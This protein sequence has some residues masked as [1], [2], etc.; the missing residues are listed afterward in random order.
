MKLEQSLQMYQPASRQLTYFVVGDLESLSASALY[1]G[2]GPKLPLEKGFGGGLTIRPLGKSS[3]L[4]I[5]EGAG[6]T[7]QIKTSKNEYQNLNSYDA[8]ILDL[9]MDYAGIK[10]VKTTDNCERKGRK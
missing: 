3:S 7:A 5:H 1:Y 4:H 10:K 2:S 9:L 8:S 6:G